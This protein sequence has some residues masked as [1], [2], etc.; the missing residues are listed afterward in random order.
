MT[1][2]HL[3]EE[4]ILYEFRGSQPAELEAGRFYRGIVDGYADFGVFVRVG[5]SV[6]GLL[7]RSQ[8]DTRLENLE[9]SEGDEVIVQVENVQNNG[10][11]DL[12]W[13]IRQSNA[14]FRGE[15]IHDPGAEEGARER[16]V[17]DPEGEEEV[18]ERPADDAD[19]DDEAV[20]APEDSEPA[21]EAPPDADASADRIRIEGLSDAVGSRVLIEGVV[22]NV[23]QTSGPTIFTIRDETGTVECAAFESAG[24]RAYPSITAD[25]AVEVLGVVERHR[26]DLQIE[27]DEIGLLEEAD[28]ED[29]GGRIASALDDRASPE[30]VDLLVEDPAIETVLDDA[31]E[32][33]TAIRRAV[34]ERT[35]IVIRHPATVDG[36]VG[37]AALERAIAGWIDRTHGDAVE[38]YRLVRRRPLRDGAYDLGDAM[39]DVDRDGQ[40]PFVLL[41]GAGS[42]REDEA[43]L[44]FLELF[45][46]DGAVVDANPRPATPTIGP[47][48]VVGTDRTATTVAATVATLVDPE[49]TDAFVHLPAVSYVEPP[50]IYRDLAAEHGY[51]DGAVTQRHDAIA[52]IAYYQ[53]YDDK[54]ELIED[55]LFDGEAAGDL[56]GHISTQYRERLDTAIETARRNVDRISTIDGE[57][58]ILDA[59]RDT[60]RFEFPPASVLADALHRA[61]EEPAVTVVLGVDECWIAGHDPA[62]IPTL[63]DRLDDELPDAGVEPTRDGLQF[64]SGRR[65]AVRTA[66]VEALTESLG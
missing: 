9:W 50:A 22:V 59:E 5:D 45:G 39:F 3:H 34:I 8:L 64:L 51:D 62:E 21:S 40:Q 43:A 18:G 2:D 11:V 55:L 6:T 17:D 37:G 31:A 35:P 65:D 14:E 10:N 12:A 26:G 61:A 49:A 38:R 53:R 15:S 36:V 52:L 4:D 29:L 44:E 47:R 46:V 60:H 33:A 7:H 56:A 32:V 23:R 13:S 57:I 16:P 27:S 42:G 48:A 41:V 24:V 30:D 54:R 63:V 28:A 66:L 1:W 20:E 25:D 19:A 58:A